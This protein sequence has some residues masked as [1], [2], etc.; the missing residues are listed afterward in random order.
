MTSDRHSSVFWP[1]ALDAAVCYACTM[2]TPAL[3]ADPSIDKS[4]ATGLSTQRGWRQLLTPRPFMLVSTAVY[5]F[6]LSLVLSGD[7]YA[8]QAQPWKTTLLVGVLLTLLTLHWFDYWFFGEKPP[9][10]AGIVLLGVRLVLV[11]MVAQI[12]GLWPVMW[13][14]ALLSYIGSL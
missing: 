3:Q 12:S 14:Y 10:R 11:E 4:Q 5:L 13:L 6:H 8:C 1:I 2:D 9:V 7:C